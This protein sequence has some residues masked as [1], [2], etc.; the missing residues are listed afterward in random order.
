MFE[1][2]TF[3]V[4]FGLAIVSSQ[5]RA[6]EA[7]SFIPVKEYCQ[8]VVSHPTLV[9]IFKALQNMEKNGV[10]V[11]VNFY[12]TI[13]PDFVITEWA[14]NKIEATV[15]A[16]YPYLSSYEKERQNKYSLS[17]KAKEVWKNYAEQVK[18]TCG[19]ELIEPQLVLS[20]PSPNV[21]K[22]KAGYD[23]C[24]SATTKKIDDDGNVKEVAPSCA[25]E[26]AAYRKAKHDDILLPEVLAFRNGDKVLQNGAEAHIAKFESDIVQA[27]AA[28]KTSDAVQDAAL[29]QRESEKLAEAAKEKT[30]I[31]RINQMKSTGD[32]SIA[33]DCGEIGAAMGA[34]NNTLLFP[35]LVSPDNKVY[36]M[37]SI[38][39]EFDG[40]HGFIQSSL[41]TNY[42][43]IL[44]TKNTIWKYKEKISIKGGVFIIGKYIGNGS[45][46]LVSGAGD[47]VRKF[48][49]IC[50]SPA[51]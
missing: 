18:D 6:D 51:Y 38:L 22:T 10:H 48:D 23:K 27:I 26:A 21:V 2:I 36:F 31:A 13:D 32:F 24:R 14:N 50:I 5:C 46:V 25:A 42:A 29:K 4:T 9:R 1:R 34:Q 49:V 28:K 15:Q 7:A 3:A 8:S 45:V 35:P 33:A 19:D 20:N 37:A 17:R 16:A 47:P 44:T 11:D 40:N 12:S 41:K 39:D 30:R 43:E